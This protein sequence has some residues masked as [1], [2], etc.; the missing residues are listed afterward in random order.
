MKNKLLEILG[1]DKIMHSIQGIIETR[2]AMIKEEIE[3]E[4]KSSLAKAI[5]LL[6][7]M[8]SIFLFILFGSITL[9]LY[10]T[11]VTENSILG[12]GI[13]AAIY[14]VLGIIFYLIRNNKAYTENIYKQ[15]K[16]KH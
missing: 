8:F 2:L 15:V 10:L 5:P 1:V 9:G 7:M 6:F 12:F 4:V 13:V 16:K 14:L 11:M 3:E